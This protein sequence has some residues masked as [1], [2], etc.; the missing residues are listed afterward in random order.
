METSFSFATGGD[1]DWFSQTTMFYNDL[2]AA[3]SGIISHNQE[4]WMQTTVNGPVTVSFYWKV[5][6]ENGYDMLE[7]YVDGSL[8]DSISGSVDWRQVDHMLPAGEH[9]LKWSY[10]KD[11]S[12]SEG[13]DSGWV[14]SFVVD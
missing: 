9:E 10:T 14:D 8:N 3:Q 6:S 2:D 7:F 11:W 4:S 12:V 5:S 1:A 13:D